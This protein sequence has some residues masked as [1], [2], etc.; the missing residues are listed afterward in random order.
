[1][2]SLKIIT[3]GLAVFAS[4]AWSADKAPKLQCESQNKFGHF[5]LTAREIV[6][7]KQNEGTMW[8]LV[9]TASETKGEETQTGRSQYLSADADYSPR[10]YKGYSRFDMSKAV[11]VS[12]FGIYA[13]LDQCRLNVLVPNNI[14]QLESAELPVVINCDQTGG[15]FTLSCTINN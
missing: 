2:N 5:T 6:I 9:V 14:N 11:D 4:S 1:M 12:N 3:L 13:P 8:D 7:S 15:T 10:K